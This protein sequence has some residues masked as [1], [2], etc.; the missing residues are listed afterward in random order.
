MPE[1]RAPG[2]YVEETTAAPAA[3]APVETAVPVFIGYT[4]RTRGRRG[5]DLTGRA[6]RIASLADYEL[7]FGKAPLQP[8]A[9]TVEKRVRP[10]GSVV[11]VTVE[12]AGRFTLPRQ[13]MPYA[14][15][16]YFDNGGGPCFVWSLGRYGRAREAD[17]RPAL[18]ALE[19]VEG[20][21]LVVLPDAVTL[22]SAGCAAVL[23]AALA[24]AARTRDR[25]VVA[26]VADALPGGCDTIADVDAHFRAA[27]SAAS[28]ARQFGAAYFPY[29]E[30]TVP[31]RSS[32]ARVTL[33]RFDV[34]TV[35]R[36][37]S[38]TAT[39]YEGAAGRRLTDRT[40][41]LAAREPEVYAAVEAFLRDARASLPPSG[42]VAGLFARTDRARGVWKAPAGEALAAVRQPA[43]AVNDAFQDVLN[44][45]PA[46]GMS[47]NA[48]R[49]FTGRGTLVWGA[50]TLAGNDSEWRYVNVRRL[51]I[52]LEQSL[53]RGL[54][55]AVFEP[56]DAN[57]WARL[58][59]AA[60]NF[61]MDLWR[62]GALQGT[63]P[64]HA[65]TVAAGLGT[66]MTQADLGAGRII[67]QVGFAPLRPAEF[68]ILRIVLQA[69]ES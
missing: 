59:A 5:A 56:N 40:L 14:L 66:T 18:Q 2:V 22:G 49:A 3:V 64:E 31:L 11:D 10:D 57:T 58:R 65:F 48:I 67:V 39:P 35:A 63:K 23:D 27:L 43:V 4:A 28:T 45:D 69:Q 51:A 68:I 26:D 44:V 12:G 61:L 36:D 52:F 21:T 60:E 29:L 6:L 32:A 53:D 41:A 34:V 46:N 16:L 19:S 50:R 47:V 42:A 13:F 20:P 15:R 8:V 1:Y 33:R 25:F 62:Q 9:V 54:Q 7:L 55:W 37:G 30:S 17:F 38:E 24:S